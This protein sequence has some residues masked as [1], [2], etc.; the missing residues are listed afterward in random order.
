MHNVATI[1]GTYLTAWCW[2][3]GVLAALDADVEATLQRYDTNNDG[4][5]SASELKAMSDDLGLGWS[6]EDVGRVLQSL[7]ATGDSTV[8]AS[9]FLTWWKNHPRSHSTTLGTKL[10]GTSDSKHLY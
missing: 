2:W 8:S 5:F 4:R 10:G 7:G 9:A 3:W 1:A 6:E